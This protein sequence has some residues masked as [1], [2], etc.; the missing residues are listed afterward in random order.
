MRTRLVVGEL[1]AQRLEAILDPH[2]ALA[3]VRKYL[4]GWIELCELRPQQDLLRV[5]G[6][7]A[8]LGVA[9][10]ELGAVADVLVELL[11]LGETIQML[12]L[13]I[14]DPLVELDD[15]YLLLL[16]LFLEERRRLLRHLRARLEVLVEVERGKSSPP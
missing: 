16:R 7:D 11:Q 5:D 3:G 4:R 6:G 8:I 9:Q 2:H 12:L 10:L 1:R 14:R 13:E 15:V